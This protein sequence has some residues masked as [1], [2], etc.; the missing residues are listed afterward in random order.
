[1]CS[2]A[3][4]ELQGVS[5]R[6]P[7]YTSPLHQLVAL[8]LRKY[9]RV[10]QFEALKP[11]DLMI[12]RG[13]FIGIVGQNGS[14]KSTLLQIVAGILRPSSGTLRVHGRIGALLELGAGFN[15]EFTGL[16][17][18]RLNAS[19]LGV[20]D[21]DFER[22][23]PDIVA[24]ADIGEFIDKPVKTFSSGMYVRLAFAIQ[25]CIEPEILIVDEALAVGDIFFRLKCYERLTRLRE[26]GCTVILVTHSMEDVIHYCDRALLLHHGEALFLGDVMET[27]S[28]YYALGGM[29]S[30]VGSPEEEVSRETEEV[31]SIDWPAVAFDDLSGRSQ[32]SDGAV[33]GLRIAMTDS[34]GRSH[35]M[36]RQGETVRIYAE[37]EAL[38]DLETVVA[39]MV[40]RTEKGVILHGKHSGQDD[41]PV[42]HSV[43]AG[44][45]LRC[46]HELKLD[47]AAGEYVVDVTIGGYATRIYDARDR[48]SMAELESAARR[49]CVISAATS[50]GVFP[51]AGNGFGVQ[52]FYGLAQLDSASHISSPRAVTE[53]VASEFT[54]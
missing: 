9:S 48:L 21:A 47:I 26:R 25:A 17:N 4:I 31:A 27:V 29:T 24:F 2:D 52:P 15:P 38:K 11:L 12:H 46:R 7:M 8:L 32:V 51:R 14:G 20:S 37:F 34:E 5:K 45:L 10:A 44:A 18:A 50:L 54:P 23:L 42:P 39:G 16:E 6:F 53:D 36:F 13:E 3:A 35:R 41:L 19:I 49:H 1:M 22:L 43:R 28:R 40:V 33:R 30:P